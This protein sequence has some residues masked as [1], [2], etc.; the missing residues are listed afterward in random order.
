VIKIFYPHGERGRDW[1]DELSVTSRQP[2]E[3][4]NSENKMGKEVRRNLPFFSSEKIQGVNGMS[5]QWKW[6]ANRDQLNQV[7]LLKLEQDG[8]DIIDEIIHI[9]SK[10]GFESIPEEKFALFKWAGVYQQRPKKDGYFMLRIRIPSGILSSEQARVIADL[11]QKYGRGLIDITTRQAVQYH[12]L[13][14]EHLP[15]I[16]RRLN[17]VGLYTYE[18]CGDCP[19]NIVGNP[20]AGI[21][22]NELVDTSPIVRALE[23]EFLL[24]REFSNLPRKY[25]ISISASIY[26]PAHA[27]IND[28]AF[29]PAVKEI[30]GEEVVGF[31]VWV[32]G[33][34]SNRPYLAQQLDIFVRP[35][36]VVEVAVAVTKIFRDYGYRQKRH[37]ARLK[38]LVADWG[39]DTFLDKLT[40]LI[41]AYPKRG[42]DRIVGWNA[43]YFTGVHRQKQEG[44][45]YVGLNVPIGRTSAEEFFA[46]ADL[47]DRYGSGSLRTVNTQNII[48]PDVPNEKVEELLKEPLLKR[49]SPFPKTFEGYAV[50]CTGNEFCNLALT[51]TKGLMKEVVEYLDAHIQLDTP[52]RIHINGCPNSCGQQQIADIGLMG[53]K[54]KTAKGV[55]ESY[56]ISIGG[57]LFGPGKFNTQLKGRIAREHVPQVLKELILFYKENREV[58][59]RFTDFVERVGVDAFQAQ[60]DRI[61]EEV[62][63][64]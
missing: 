21:D 38:F 47:A 18:A 27:Q 3:V 32:G 52:I 45:S 10:N 53:G 49:L 5:K 8:L 62:V 63:S 15:E 17:E 29:T 16:F 60:L 55:V 23:K 14:I 24:N 46:L 20:L 41:G 51:E 9:Y 35:E 1:L 22:P 44:L 31:H 28:L 64:F 34:L 59:E 40:E 30:D 12:W 54:S 33:G 39:V 11:S 56:T 37:R 13:R 42:E 43:G 19:R 50:S 48:I 7:E 2:C 61:T 25:K 26:N 36:Q 6:E 57:H 4:P 58:G